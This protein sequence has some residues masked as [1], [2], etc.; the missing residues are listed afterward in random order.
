MSAQ[1][2]KLD[3][4]N[5]IKGLAALPAAKMLGAF[6]ILSA[7]NANANKL[8]PSAKEVIKVDAVIVGSTPRQL[9]KAIQLKNTGL[10]VAVLDSR[11]NIGGGIHTECGSKQKIICQNSDNT[12]VDLRSLDVTDESQYDDHLTS[13]RDRTSAPRNSSQQNLKAF[14]SRLGEAGNLAAQL[15]NEIHL[16]FSIADIRMTAS[17]NELSDYGQRVIVARQV[18]WAG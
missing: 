16:N 15:K 10:K 1:K 18:L 5:A 7:G 4:R 17:G 12:K 13:L 3:R 9:E 2:F 8:I 14:E 11:P 6:S